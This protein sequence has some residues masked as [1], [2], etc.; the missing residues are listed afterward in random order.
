MMYGG[1]IKNLGELCV[2][3]GELLVGLRHSFA[4]ADA[5]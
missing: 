5:T 2:L 4:R 3:S 1:K